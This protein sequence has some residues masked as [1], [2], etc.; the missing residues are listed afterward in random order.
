MSSPRMPR[1]QYIDLGLTPPGEQAT[2]GHQNGHAPEQRH[3]TD[4]GNA[5]RLAA[6]HGDDLRYV[7]AWNRWLVWNQQRWEVDDGGEV[8]RLAKETVRTIYAEAADA[9]DS[10]ERKAIA[11]HAKSSESKARL[12]AMIALAESEPGIPVKPDALDADPWLLNVANGTLDLR[13]GELREHHRSDLITKLAPVEYDPDAEA[14]VWTAFL[15]RILPGE[16]LR[17]FVQK[18]TGYSATGNTRERVMLLLHGSGKNG[19]STFLEAVREVLGDEDG[20]AQK[21]PAETLMAKPSG[22]IP[23]DVARL[24]GARFVSASETGEGRRLDES[25]VKEITGNDTISA[26]FMRAEWFDFR[27]SHK[28]WLATNHK[29]VIKG[30]DPAIWDRIKL[31]PF[32]QRI[33]EEEQDRNLPE[34]LQ[35][36]LSG[37][38]RW[39]VEGCIEW[40]SDGLGEPAEVKAATAGY[41]AEQDVLGGF[42]EECCT[43]HEDA[44]CRFA[45]LY[46]EYTRWCEA[47]GEKAQTKRQFG[48]ALSERGFESANGAKNVAIRLGIALRSGDDPPGG[49]GPD[50]GSG[51]DNPE[52]SRVNQD[53]AESGSGASNKTDDASQSTSEVNPQA[54]GLIKDNPGNPH[55]YQ[56]NPTWVNQGYPNFGINEPNI[57]HVESTRNPINLVNPVNPDDA[58]DGSRKPRNA[59]EERQANEVIEKAVAEGM[60]RELARREVLGEEEL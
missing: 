41:R 59:D 7:H 2:N 49:D 36:E 55:T 54:Q 27:P 58:P 44:W 17:R 51:D 12:E 19:K 5:E 47:S 40:Q 28:T 3:L 15:E 10:S 21:T 23:N 9:E 56:E 20:Y 57:S 60:E 52:G 39:I 35:G 53:F 13:T 25:L 8:E 43:V 33:P 46:D 22:G 4:M 18:A 30:T 6:Q 48:N 26:R 38:L 16:E 34:K 31:V 45:N 1:Q 32:E 29:P 14:P 24:K 42:I 50:K 37:I 11:A